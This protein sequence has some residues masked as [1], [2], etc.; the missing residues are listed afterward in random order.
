MRTSRSTHQDGAHAPGT[1]SSTEEHLD[2]S[3]L[4]RE[5]A[6]EKSLPLITGWLR[7]R[8]LLEA[9]DVLTG[10]IDAPLAQEQSAGPTRR[11]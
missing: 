8:I 3:P 6:D 10:I 5:R 1:D 9:L 4:A 7:V 11:R 2:F